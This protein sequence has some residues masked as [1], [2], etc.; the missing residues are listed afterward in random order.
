MDIKLSDIT[1]VIPSDREVVQ[2]IDS[3]P[4]ECH[5]IIRRDPTQGEA[6]NMGIELA[7]TEWIAFADGDIRFGKVFLDYVFTLAGDRVIVG[8]QGYWPSPFLISRFLF[9]KKS[10]WE[11]VGKLKH[12]RHGEETEWLIRAVE[13]GYKLVGVPRESVYHYPHKKLECKKEYSNLLWLLRLHPDFPL[14][15]LK[16]VVYKMEK[17]SY[18]EEYL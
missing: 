4:K 5:Y 16:S 10:V 2:T 8:L 13:K 17:S 14:R 1:F 3:I 15:I 6:R 18:D 9:F 7:Q 12:V 11:D